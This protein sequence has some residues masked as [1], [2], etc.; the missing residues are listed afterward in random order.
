MRIAAAQIPSVDGDINTNIQYHLQAIT[1]AAQHQISMLIFPEMSLTGYLLKDAAQHAISVDDSRLD[2][3]TDVAQKYEMTLAIGAPINTPDSK[4][5]F[6]GL[7]IFHPNG[8]REQYK[9]MFLHGEENDYFMSGESAKVFQHM[10][11]KIGLAICADTNHTEH[12]KLL[13]NQHASIYAASVMFTAS[14]YDV[15]AGALRS[16]SEQHNMLTLMANYNVESGGWPGTGK[17]AVYWAGKELICADRTLN[18]L[19]IAEY[20][21]GQWRGDLVELELNF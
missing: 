21:N 19:V 4:D 18:Q 17:S 3:F 6:I 15:D 11:H 1:Q 14:A 20:N 5:I 12:P 8:N 16:Y 10:E 2:V 13:A 7:I 9:K